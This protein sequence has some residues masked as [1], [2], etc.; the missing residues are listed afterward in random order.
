MGKYYRVKRTGWEEL[1]KRF[2]SFSKSHFFSQ[3]QLKVS[4]IL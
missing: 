4:L 1:G 2:L 3:I